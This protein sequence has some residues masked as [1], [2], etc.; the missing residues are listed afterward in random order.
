[1]INA[2]ANRLAAVR[3]RLALAGSSVVDGSEDGWVATRWGRKCYFATPE[4]LESFAN[5]V[6]A[7]A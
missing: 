6:G 1:M 5:R 2:E 7:K 4:G 3:A